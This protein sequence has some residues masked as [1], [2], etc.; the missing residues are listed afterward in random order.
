MVAH[1]TNDRDE[2]KPLT[3]KD[4][5]VSDSFTTGL[6]S[7]SFIGKTRY[8]NIV[9]F[10]VNNQRHI[11]TSGEVALL[12]RVEKPFLGCEIE[13]YYKQTDVKPHKDGKTESFI[14]ETNEG[15]D[16]EPFTQSK[17]PL[18][19]KIIQLNNQGLKQDDIAKIIGRSRKW[20]NETMQKHG[21]TSAYKKKT[22]K[23]EG[24]AEQAAPFFTLLHCRSCGIVWFLWIFSF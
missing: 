1:T 15:E 13:G 20:V 2:W 14:D 5:A 21:I 16:E 9:L 6:D 18:V 10:K 8:E 17:D 12:K 19:E 22:Q 4:V 11:R 3:L 23:D 7:I 24:V